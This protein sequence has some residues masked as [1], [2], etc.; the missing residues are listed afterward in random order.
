MS[1]ETVIH[2]HDTAWRRFEAR[3]LGRGGFSSDELFLNALE[4]AAPLHDLGEPM[5][6]VAAEILRV[7]PDLEPATWRGLLALVVASL[8]WTRQGST[9]IPI[10]GPVAD[11]RLRPLLESLTRYAEPL[12]ADRNVVDELIESIRWVVSSQ[13]APSLI[14]SNSNAYTPFIHVA[15]FLYPQH[16]LTL[17]RST[18]NKVA[19]LLARPMA[20]EGEGGIKA[21]RDALVDVLK[22]KPGILE[23]SD[24]QQM[25]VAVAAR[26]P[27][28]VLTGGPGTGKTSI[29]VGILRVLARLGVKP[30]QIALAAPTG[31]A[32]YRLGEAIRARWPRSHHPPKKTKRCWRRT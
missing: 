6:H 28:A 16:L 11:A 10:E 14:G 23:L 22:R 12:T 5:V 21:V 2:P 13:A 3:E 17:E 26:A 4:R 1:H 20:L 29:V 19:S 24:E 18:S 7:E 8:V 32:A 30:E 15:P 27:L 25:A 31:R 9:R